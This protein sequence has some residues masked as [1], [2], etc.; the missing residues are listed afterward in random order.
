[1]YAQPYRI[2]RYAPELGNK[3]TDLIKLSQRGRRNRQGVIN[4][5]C[6]AVARIQGGSEGF[7]DG[8]I[9]I[10]PRIVQFRQEMGRRD[11][12]GEPVRNGYLGYHFS[13]LYFASGRN[14]RGF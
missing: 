6:T 7:R 8:D 9:D 12:G 5:D 11:N 1:M 2:N 13:Q 10:Q 3:S 14:F 4:G